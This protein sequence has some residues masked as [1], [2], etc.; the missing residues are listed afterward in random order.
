MLTQVNHPAN[1]CYVAY[2]IVQMYRYVL[3]STYKGHSL[4]HGSL[5]QHQQMP[6]QTRQLRQVSGHDLFYYI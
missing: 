5:F 3:L 2:L 6:H 4:I 1:P